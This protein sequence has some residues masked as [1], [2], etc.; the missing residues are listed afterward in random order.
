MHETKLPKCLSDK[1]ERICKSADFDRS[2]KPNKY[3]SSFFTGRRERERDGEAEFATS[4]TAVS[5]VVVG[6]G[7]PCSK[8]QRPLLR[9]R[10]EKLLFF[11][12]IY[13]IECIRSQIRI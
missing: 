10:G 8:Q 2:M 13:Y 1:E 5:P 12:V 9:L 6:G 4:F 3:Y 7:L 11:R